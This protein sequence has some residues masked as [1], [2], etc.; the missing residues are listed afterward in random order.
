MQNTTTDIA[1]KSNHRK[2]MLTLLVAVLGYFVDVYDLAIFAIVRIK[3]LQSFGL[4]GE[5]LLNTGAFLLN[6]Q[7]IGMA[8]GGLLWG[9]LGDKKGRLKIM[10]SSILLYSLATLAN[11]FVTDIN[12]YAICRFIAGIGLA[13]E[14][15]VSFTLAGEMISKHKRG[16]VMAGI[17]ALGVLGSVTAGIIGENFSWETTFIV[18]GVMGFALLL[19]RSSIAESSMFEKTAQ[20]SDVKKGDIRLILLS[21]SR[22]IRYMACLTIGLTTWFPNLILLF[23][24]EIGEALGIP[25]I[26][27]AYAA[28]FSI[29]GLAVGDIFTSLV[30]YYFCNRK[31]VLITFLCLASIFTFYILEAGIKSSN[32]F[33]LLSAVIGF[34]SGYWALLLA[35]TAEQFGTNLRATVSTSI[36]NFVRGLGAV[37]IIAF[38]ILKNQF[39]IV[40]GTEILGISLFV[41]GL[42]AIYFL[43]ETYGTD[44]NFV[45]TDEGEA[46]ITEPETVVEEQA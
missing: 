41:F 30:S 4:E 6:M 17:A 18:G 35:T 2:V 27:V 40:A 8:I 11:A 31:K 44:L 12:Q 10:Y 5:A 34:F 25:G 14:I 45:E 28:I 38:Q 37:I 21:P 36:P 42:V 24:P 15:G 23:S 9:V 22:L 29:V 13:G 46:L 16:I 43:K 7:L 39:G 19:L 3:S 32:T 1:D 33:Y 20:R 26:S